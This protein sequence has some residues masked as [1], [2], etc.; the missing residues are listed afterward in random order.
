MSS[1]VDV[2]TPTQAVSMETFTEIVDIPSLYF[3]SLCADTV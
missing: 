1:C 2:T 3:E